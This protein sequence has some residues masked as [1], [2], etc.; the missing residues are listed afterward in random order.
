MLDPLAYALL[1][2]ELS[3]VREARSE[4]PRRSRW[5]RPRLRRRSTRRAFA[6]APAVAAC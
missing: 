3:P 1:N 6:P 4:R 2:Q 5:S